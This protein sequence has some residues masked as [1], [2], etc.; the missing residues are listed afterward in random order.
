MVDLRKN[1]VHSRKQLEENWK[2]FYVNQSFIYVNQS[3]VYVNPLLT[4]KVIF[5]S[6]TYLQLVAKDLLISAVAKA[7]MT[8][9]LVSARN[10]TSYATA[11]ATRVAQLVI[12]VKLL[13]TTTTTT[14]TTT[15][16]ITKKLKVYTFT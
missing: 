5:I 1:N 2:K 6:P 11:A 8:L 9:T 13:P 15:T 3:C 4:G 16:Y 7:R 14:T 10:Q 12:T